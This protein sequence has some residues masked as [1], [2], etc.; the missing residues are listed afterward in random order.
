[1]VRHAWKPALLK[2]RIEVDMTETGLICRDGS[3]A[4]QWRLD[5]GDVAAAVVVEHTV[6]GTSMRRLDLLGRDG[7]VLRRLSCT[8]PPGAPVAGT[9]AGAYVLAMAAILDRLGE[10]EI[11]VTVGEYGRARVAIFAVGVVSV[12][13][14]FGIGVAA[15]ASGISGDRLAGAAVPILLLVVFGLFLVRANA[16]WRKRPEL[17]AGLVAVALRDLVE[18][19][20]PDSASADREKP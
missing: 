12:L 6:R 7:V 10:R 3:G 19:Q 5:W 20:E 4:E 18:G 2:G 17:P 16:P 15:L 11:A 14:G 8:G 13:G 1:M 9:E